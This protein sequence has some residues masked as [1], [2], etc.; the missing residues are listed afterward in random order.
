M[1][2]YSGVDRE[3][4]WAA[5]FAKLQTALGD[6]LVTMSRQH[7]MPPTLTPE[8]Q[9]A[10]FLVQARETRKPTP[11]GAPVQLV[12]NG[13]LIL[14]LQVP[15][16]LDEIP[17]EETTLA[18]TQM[19]ALLQSVDDAMQPDDLTTGRLT[20]GGLITHGWIEG[21]VEMDPGIFSQQGAAILPVK[22]LVP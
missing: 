11:A 5:L 2:L 1:G 3:A 6:D 10:L 13:F 4:C 9:P 8:Q 15:A 17:G 12:L 22:M 21:D 16:P 20:L 19:N 14:Y 7:I 18:A